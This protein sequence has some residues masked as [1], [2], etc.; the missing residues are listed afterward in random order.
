[1]EPVL[2]Q[3][4][5]AVGY[6]DALGMD[7]DQAAGDK[8]SFPVPFKC[9][10]YR[11]QMPVTE[12]SAGDTTTAIVKFD[13][14]PAAGSDTNRGDGDI[15]NIACGTTAAGKVLYDNAARGTVLYPGEE[16]VVELAQAATGT[17]KTGHGHPQ[18]LVVPIPE[19]EANLSAMTETA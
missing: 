8:G 13:K 2:L 14:R 6:N 15:A 9:S 11:A 18:L 5:P 10:V 4:H 12:N 7:F 19:M 17:T 3:Y 16:V 1:M